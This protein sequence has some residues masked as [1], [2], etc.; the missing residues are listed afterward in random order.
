MLAGGDMEIPYVEILI[1]S[2][3][4]VFQ[5]VVFVRW[6]GRTRGSPLMTKLAYWLFDFLSDASRSVLW[7]T[8]VLAL[9]LAFWFIVCLMLFLVHEYL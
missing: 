6:K 4:L 3:V 5:T 7:R 8:T 1:A 2:V 9:H